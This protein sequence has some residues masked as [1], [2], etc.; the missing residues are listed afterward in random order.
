MFYHSYQEEIYPKLFTPAMIIMHNLKLDVC[1]DQC[2][3]NPGKNRSKTILIDHQIIFNFMVSSSRSVWRYTLATLSE[4]CS[5]KNVSQSK[6]P[7]PNRLTRSNARASH[8]LKKLNRA[9]IPKGGSFFWRREIAAV[10]NTDQ[11]KIF[12]SCT[13]F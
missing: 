13:I 10:T 6:K 4:I 5:V 9:K 12:L 2:R 7:H 1:I 8:V 11:R 3:K